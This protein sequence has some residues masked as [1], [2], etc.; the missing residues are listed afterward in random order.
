MRNFLKNLFFYF[1]AMTLPKGANIKTHLTDEEKYFLHNL[2]PNKNS[3][4][5]EIG[6]YLGMSALCIASS[7]HCKTLY[8]VDTWNNEGMSEG[9][10]DTYSD[11]VKNTIK[12]NDKIIPLR[13]DSYTIGLSF[14]F[15][16]DFL[17]IDGD[18]SYEGAKKDID[19]WLP[20]LR[21]GGIL[22]MHDSGWAEGIQK[23]ILNHVL[24]FI[25]DSRYLSNMF[26]GRR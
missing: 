3:V 7:K 22:L 14:K 21:S 9:S 20:K 13:G 25:N 1:Y 23:V 10:R 2:L 26:I 6:S 4:C 8:C 17:F 12:Y 5:V 11:F 24:P 18:H 16:I 19:V 15:D